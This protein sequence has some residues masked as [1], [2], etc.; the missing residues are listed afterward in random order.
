MLNGGG[1]G[2]YVVIKRIGPVAYKLE[3]PANLGRVH[4]VFHISQLRKYISDP[5]HVLQTDVLVIEPNLAYEERPIRILDWKKKRLRNKVVSLVKV[6]WRCDK[7][8]EETWETE[9]FMRAKHPHLFERGS[10][11]D[12]PDTDTFEV[13]DSIED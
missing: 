7:F 1:V 9:N 5:N 3:L 11:L 10:N 4:D 12:D 2:P 8:E 13:D 6:L